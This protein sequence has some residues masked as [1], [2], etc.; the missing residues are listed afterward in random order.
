MVS[1]CQ[2]RPAQLGYFRKVKDNQKER[3]TRITSAD[4]IVELCQDEKSKVTDAFL[5]TKRWEDF[6]IAKHETAVPILCIPAIAFQFL[7]YGYYGKIA[8]DKNLRR[9]LPFRGFCTE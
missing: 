6:G 2:G 1:C 3:S 9:K 7:K 4:A 8:I 5:I